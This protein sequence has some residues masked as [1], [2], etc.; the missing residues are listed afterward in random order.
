VVTVEWLWLAYDRVSI[1]G[2]RQ[3]MVLLEP[4]CRKFDRGA[5]MAAAVRAGR[6]PLLRLVGG[7]G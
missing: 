2:Q 3:W 4:E 7:R 6:K 1:P 5:M